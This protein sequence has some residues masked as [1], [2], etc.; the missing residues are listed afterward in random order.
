MTRRVKR[1]IG[2]ASLAQAEIGYQL[3]LARGASVIASM[4]TNENMTAAIGET[5]ATFVGAHGTADLQIFVQLLGQRL[6]ERDRSDA[7]DILST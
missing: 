6:V 5:L 2:T 7:A 4:L 1:K 3:E